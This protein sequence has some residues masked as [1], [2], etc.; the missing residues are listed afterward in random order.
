MHRQRKRK[1][2]LKQKQKQRRSR[3]TLW[4]G[5]AETKKPIRHILAK[6]RGRAAEGT[7]DPSSRT[8]FS[9]LACCWFSVSSFSPG[10]R[11][12]IPLQSSHHPHKNPFLFP[13]QNSKWLPSRREFSGFANCHPNA[14]VSIG[15]LTDSCVASLPSSLMAS[16]VASL[17]PSSAA[18][19]TA[20]TFLEKECL[21]PAKYHS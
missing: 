10:R 3:T 21:S 20:G 19:R 1:Q 7:D 13:T 14:K 17:A 11:T 2:K 15:W 4:A 5:P 8:F 16:S 12:T 6:W 18:S 9:L